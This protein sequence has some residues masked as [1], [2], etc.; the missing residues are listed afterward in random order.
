MGSDSYPALFSNYVKN[1]YNAVVNILFKALS[2]LELLLH[3]VYP[4]L[5]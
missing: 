3:I 1:L 5:M 2:S 4:I